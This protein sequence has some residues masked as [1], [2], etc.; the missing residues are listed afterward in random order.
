MI[1][2]GECHVQ[3]V[4]LQSDVNHDGVIDLSY[5]GP[6]TAN[7]FRPFRFWVNN[8]GD[9]EESDKQS[10]TFQ[11]SANATIECQRD[12]EDFAR[13]WVCGLPVLRAVDGY[14]AEL[15]IEAYSGNPSINLYR[16]R[17]PAGGVGYLTDTS[18]AADQFTKVYLYEQLMFDYGSKLATIA[19]GSSYTIPLDAINGGLSF[20]RFLFEGVDRGSGRLVLAV[21]RD[22]TKLVETSA[23]IDLR[24]AK[25]LYEQAI[26]TSV[27][28]QWPEMVEENHV[29]GFQLQQVPDPAPDGYKEVAVFVHGWRMSNWEYFN[30]AETMYKRLY[31]QGYQ[32]RFAAL[33]W[34]TRSGDTDPFFG[35]DYATY[36]RSEHI[37]FKSGT[38]TAAYLNDLRQRFPDHTISVCAHSMGNIVMM[39]ALKDLAAASQAPIDNYVLMQAAVPAQ[40][41]DT[42]VTNLPAFIALEQSVPTPDAYNNYAG[43]ISGSLR[44]AGNLFNFFSAA[45]FAIS[46]TW[47]LNQKFCSTLDTNGPVTMKPN[48]LLGYYSDGVNHVLRTNSWNQQFLSIVY[49]GYYEGATRTVANF[50]EIVPFVARPRSKALGAQAGVHGEI[51][52][53]EIDLQEI[54]YGGGSGDHSG[55]WNRNIQEPPIGSFYSLLKARLFPPQ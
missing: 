17:D 35:L 22:E 25:E 5:T 42:S 19:P 28:Q 1:L 11:N 15:S 52:G 7:E 53:A 16:S 2:P 14:R 51:G 9:L 47:E 34:P 46:T 27:Q 38:G 10:F 21:Y 33:R 20:D 54:G 13:L 48:T 45:D 24:D 30:F 32:G 12:L 29:S 55:Q 26:V 49:G 37:A 8:D 43:G 4:K 18:A 50:H 41:Y 39:Q 6:D 40:C 36:N 3:V 23:Y 44:G 31:W